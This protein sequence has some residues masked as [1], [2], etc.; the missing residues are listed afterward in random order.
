MA[1]P[2]GAIQLAVVSFIATFLSIVAL[3][4]RLWSKN[5][6]CRRMALHDYMACVAM[7]LAAGAVSVFLAAGFAAGLGL[8]AD[9]ILATNPAIFPLY[10]KF[11]VP[12]QLL[13]AAANTCVKI[14]IL[15]LYT[16]LFPS[17]RFLLLCYATMV[18]TSAFFISVLLETF[19]LCKPVQFNWDKSIAGTCEGQNI[20]YLVRASQTSLLTFCGCHAHAHALGAPHVAAEAV[21][22][23]RNVQLGSGDLHYLTVEDHLAS[24]LG[25]DRH[26][27]HSHAGRHL[28]RAGTHAWRRERLPPTH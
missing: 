9:Y 4:L 14:S 19:V 8:H 17:Y 25:S 7:V 15:S 12:A 11:F 21:G 28:F 26:D 10:F 16:S 20:A 6:Q 3:A 24:Q 2:P 27:V 18:A 1:L 22:R 5:I 23:H 13:W